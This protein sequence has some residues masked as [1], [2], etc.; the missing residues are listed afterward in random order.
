MA[1]MNIVLNLAI[2]G[3][4]F[5]SYYNSVLTTFLANVGLNLVFDNFVVRPTMALIIG[6]PISLS[7][8][9]HEY[10][11]ECQQE[12]VLL[13]QYE[14]VGEKEML[15]KPPKMMSPSKIPKNIPIKMEKEPMNDEFLRNKD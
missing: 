3:A 8:S 15:L 11:M 4:V 10:V 9:V 5:K 2:I 6:I 12:V 1:V 14:L 13:E 7:T